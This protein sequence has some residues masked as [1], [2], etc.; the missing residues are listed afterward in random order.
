[1]KRLA[2]AV[3]AVLLALSPLGLAADSWGRLFFN[4]HERAQQLTTERSAA[5]APADATPAPLRY[6]GQL[7]GPRRQVHWVNGVEA[8]PPVGLRPGQ[9]QP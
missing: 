3:C 9:Q 1:M 7:K 2:L 6:D 4:P 5:A 8:T